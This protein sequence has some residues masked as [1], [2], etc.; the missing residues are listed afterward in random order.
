MAK[1][2]KDTMAENTALCCPSQ[3]CLTGNG[4]KDC[5]PQRTTGCAK[6]MYQ[7]ATATVAPRMV[8]LQDRIIRNISH[9][10]GMATHPIRKKD[11]RKR[12]ALPSDIM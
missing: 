9:N 6:K 2:G 1:H 10:A 11:Y 5:S 8:P 12:E 3:Q 7:A 4:L